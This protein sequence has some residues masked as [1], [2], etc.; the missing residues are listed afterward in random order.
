MRAGLA[1][2]L[3]K[4][5]LDAWPP[6]RT[7]AEW[8]RRAVRLTLSRLSAATV[9]VAIRAAGAAGC[10]LVVEVDERRLERRVE[11]RGAVVRRYACR[12][13]E[14]RLEFVVAAARAYARREQLLPTRR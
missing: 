9:G 6:A 13:R 1:L 3:E 4:R 11:R 5:E 12:A 7:E 10:R 8:R 14:E 2:L